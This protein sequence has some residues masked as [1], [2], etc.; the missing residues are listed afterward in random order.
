MHCISLGQKLG[1]QLQPHQ[2]GQHAHAHHKLLPLELRDDSIQVL[3]LVL[4]GI[5]AL[6]DLD[7]QDVLEL[8][9]ADDDGGT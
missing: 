1:C 9:Q 5:L 6:L 8:A 4:D 7:A 3:D 2:K